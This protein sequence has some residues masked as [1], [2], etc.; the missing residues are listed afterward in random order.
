M[1][2]IYIICLCLCIISLCAF[3]LVYD[4][5]HGEFSI[6]GKT[7]SITHSFYR[8]P[9]LK[10]S[11]PGM[12]ANG[13]FSK[14]TPYKGAYS[15][16]FVGKELPKTGTYSLKEFAEKEGET[17]LGVSGAFPNERTYFAVS[18]EV[19]VVNNGKTLNV[20]FSNVPIKLP[21]GQVKS[22]TSGNITISLK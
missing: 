14:S 4:A 22:V 3:S 19:K 13:W 11:S 18:G 7:Y 16:S 21:Y 17:Q 10:S 1:K 15:I 6:D 8:L 9:D 20:T 2:R 5:N 12:M